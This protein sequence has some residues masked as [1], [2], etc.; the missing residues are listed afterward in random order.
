M[1]NTFTEF[2]R[3]I[4]QLLSGLEISHLIFSVLDKK[5]MMNYSVHK[6]HMKTDLSTILVVP[7][8]S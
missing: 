5:Y 6:L 4:Q 2:S 8:L 7:L 3:E 1:W